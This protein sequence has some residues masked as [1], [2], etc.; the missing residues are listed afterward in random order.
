MKNFRC[1]QHHSGSTWCSRV[2]ALP[3]VVLPALI[4]SAYFVSR[5]LSAS[6]GWCHCLAAARG[7]ALR[8]ACMCTQVHVWVSSIVCI[9]S[10]YSVHT[11]RSID[12]LATA[13]N[14]HTA[15]RHWV[16]SPNIKMTGHITIWCIWCS[17]IRCHLKCGCPVIFSS[18]RDVIGLHWWYIWFHLHIGNSAIESVQFT[19]RNQFEVHKQAIII[20]YLQW[21][22]PIKVNKL[23][24]LKRK[25]S[26]TKVN[27]ISCCTNG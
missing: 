12:C 1:Q 16:D 24:F 13:H 3:Q 21:K 26:T 7:F 10:L 20:Q 22:L 19:C 18:Q 23:R 14:I 6:I 2:L 4:H 9:S 17:C 27:V 8:C 11:Y 25:L 5:R 15:D